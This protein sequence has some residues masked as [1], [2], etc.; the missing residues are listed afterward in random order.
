M[1][2]HGRK[3]VSATVCTT[4]TVHQGRR[5]AVPKLRTAIESTSVRNAKV[6]DRKTNPRRELLLEPDNVIL[7]LVLMLL[8]HEEIY[9]AL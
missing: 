9:Q 7:R 5:V 4:P 8:K 1:I 6:K 2:E 3:G